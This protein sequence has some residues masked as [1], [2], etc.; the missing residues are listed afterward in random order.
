MTWIDERRVVIA[1]GGGPG[2]SI[3]SGHYQLDAT[4]A[5]NEDYDLQRANVRPSQTAPIPDMATVP[6]ELRTVER[7]QLFVDGKPVGDAFP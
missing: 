1:G 4:G 7:K 5:W 2:M 3:M 6:V